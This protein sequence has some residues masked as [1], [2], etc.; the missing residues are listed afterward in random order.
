MSK[1]ESS[2]DNLSNSEAFFVKEN[3]LLEPRNDE[4]KMALKFVR[5]LNKNKESKNSIF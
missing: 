3:P 4:E 2:A 1:K 5:K